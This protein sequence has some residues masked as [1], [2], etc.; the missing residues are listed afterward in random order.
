MDTVTDRCRSVGSMD[1]KH[2]EFAL[3]MYQSLGSDSDKMKLCWGRNF[4]VR[5]TMI[6]AIATRMPKIYVAPHTHFPSKSSIDARLRLASM[7]GG[8]LD[9]SMGYLTF[10]KTNDA[11]KSRQRVHLSGHTSM[12]HTFNIPLLPKESIQRCNEVE[13]NSIF[14]GMTAT[15]DY[16]SDGGNDD[17]GNDMQAIEVT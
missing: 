15:T 9:L 3:D 6:A 1:N 12:Q 7:S 17:G 5:K 10:K 11:E 14:R 16:D 2:F 13:R 4:K 8:A